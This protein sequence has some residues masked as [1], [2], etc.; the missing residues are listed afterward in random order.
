MSEK[1]NEIFRLKA[2]ILQALGH[3]VRLKIVDFLSKGEKCVCEIVQTLKSERTG[4]SKH[5]SILHRSGIL[6]FRK[7]GKK[8]IYKL[9]IPCALNFLSCAEEIIKHNL[10]KRI[11][12]I[13]G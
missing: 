6:S 2:E 9:E 3:P 8:I 11:K 12:L 5:L 10:G 13:K 7:D 4:I 1:T